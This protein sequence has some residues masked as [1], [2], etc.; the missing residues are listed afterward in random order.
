MAF[1]TINSQSDPR[2]LSKVEDLGAIALL[3]FSCIFLNIICN[4]HLIIF[5]VRV[6]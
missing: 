5:S 4:Q 6:K 3:D 2:L 1:E